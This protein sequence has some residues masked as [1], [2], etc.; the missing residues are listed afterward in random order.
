VPLLL[1]TSAWIEYLRDTGSPACAEVA[2]LMRRPSALATTEPIVMEL[3][4][5][6]PNPRAQREL[7]TLAAGL[8]LLSVDIAVDY[9]D[10]AAIYRAVRGTGRT[11]RRMND[12]LIA[13]VAARTG[14]TLV[15]RDADFDGI[16]DAVG[17]DVRRLI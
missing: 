12:C 3:L 5:G 10:A 9:H 4:A 13:A 1:D 8:P 11:V 6:A 7:E 2:R 14:A 15:H 16:A 17:L